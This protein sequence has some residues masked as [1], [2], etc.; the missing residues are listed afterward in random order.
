MRLFRL[1]LPCLLACLLALVLPVLGQKRFG[2]LFGVVT[3]ASGAAL[4][5][6]TVIIT[7]K[8]I[9]KIF[10]TTTGSDGSYIA[11]D[12]EPGRYTIRIEAKGFTPNEFPDV[13]LIVGKR[14]RLDAPMKVGMRSEERRVGK[15]CR[16]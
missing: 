6:A 5:G 15:E 4:P 1:G 8:A 13:I 14:I 16:L 10:N 12:L 2:E 7:N 11:R 9:G 3:D